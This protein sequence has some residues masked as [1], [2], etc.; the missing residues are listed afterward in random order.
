[1]L[2]FG[3]VRFWASEYLWPFP[4]N[5]N[6]HKMG[7]FISTCILRSHPLG[8]C[9]FSFPFPIYFFIKQV[10]DPEE[11]EAKKTKGSSPGMQDPQDVEDGTPETDEAPMDVIRSCFFNYVDWWENENCH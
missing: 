7:V 11:P 6:L 10:E 8:T 4:S 1:M 3:L 5:K 2:T 9:Y